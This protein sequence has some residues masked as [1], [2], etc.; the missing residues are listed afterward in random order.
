MNQLFVAMFNYKERW[1]KTALEER[2][3]LA[4]GLME[5]LGAALDGD[6]E[7]MGFAHNDR[8]A[9]RSARYDLFCVYRTNHLHAREALTERF[10]TLGWHDYFDQVELGGAALS[11]LG[12]MLDAVALQNAATP[13]SSI[14]AV[15]PYAKT[16]AT[17]KGRRMARVDVGQGESI[18]FLHG[19][20]TSSYL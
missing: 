3:R 4:N 6:V 19:D 13:K 7:V 17:V 20:V 15:M 1:K 10:E 12:L 2:Q 16:F 11:P 18:V 14:R 8:Q 5:S 9:E